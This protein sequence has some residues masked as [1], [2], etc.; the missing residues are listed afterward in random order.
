[1]GLYDRD[2]MKA[3]SAR[4]PVRKPTWWQRLRFRIWQLFR[5]KKK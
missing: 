5:K 3:P 4:R 1:M 2:Y